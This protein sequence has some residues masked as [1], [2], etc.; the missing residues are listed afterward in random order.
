MFERLK[1][2]ADSLKSIDIEKMIDE[3]LNELMPE[4]LDL[5]TD[6]LSKGQLKDGDLLEKYKSD[7]YYEFKLSLGTYKAPDGV[8]D[9]FV[10]GDFYNGFTGIIKS[11]IIEIK[12]TDS[13]ANDLESNYSSDIYGL[14]ENNIQYIRNEIIPRVQNKLRSKIKI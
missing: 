12:S 8:A 3:I 2:L 13:K 7:S 9:L 6:Q 5:N 11:D 1:N 10:D 14:N 4:I